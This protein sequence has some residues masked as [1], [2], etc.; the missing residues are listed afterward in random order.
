MDPARVRTRII[1]LGD[2]T[3]PGPGGAGLICIDDIYIARSV[4]GKEPFGQIE[5]RGMEC[6]ETG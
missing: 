1:G 5:P 2:R 3:D 6:N 4:N